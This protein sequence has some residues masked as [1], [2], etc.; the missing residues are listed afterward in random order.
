MLCSM[1]PF[2]LFYFSRSF[3]VRGIRVAVYHILSLFS[4]TYLQQP[5]SCSDDTI[6]ALPFVC[7]QKLKAK[8]Y[9]GLLYCAPM[10]VYTSHCL[11]CFLYVARNIQLPTWYNNIN[12]QSSCVSNNYYYTYS[13]STT[14][15]RHIGGTSYCKS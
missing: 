1:F 14:D 15:K 9:T 5:K 12:K 4:Y 7:V 13:I 11:S 2:M 6:E 8:T 10:P 3:R